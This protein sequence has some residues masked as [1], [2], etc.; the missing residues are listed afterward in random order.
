MSLKMMTNLTN[1]TA[2]FPSFL[3]AHLRNLDELF[4]YRMKAIQDKQQGLRTRLRNNQKEIQRLMTDYEKFGAVIVSG[5]NVADMATWLISD[6]PKRRAPAGQSPDPVEPTQTTD[7]S[8][9]PSQSTLGKSNVSD[10]AS[11]ALEATFSDDYTGSSEDDEDTQRSV[12][13]DTG[14]P[15]TQA[16]E[17]PYLS[18]TQKRKRKR[19]RD[20]KE[21][22]KAKKAMKKSKRSK[23]KKGGGTPPGSP[24]Y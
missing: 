21:A 15:D 16:S 20:K 23:A 2:V 24:S 13:T 1:P 17:S 11:A 12:N 9:Q 6:R 5:N 3:N 8:T 19:K 4:T 7:I 18:R 10:A 14:L 22:K